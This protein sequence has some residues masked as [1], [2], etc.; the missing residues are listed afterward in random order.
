VTSISAAVWLIAA[1]LLAPAGLVARASAPQAGVAGTVRSADG[2]ALANARVVVRD[3]SHEATAT[4][5]AAGAFTAAGVSLPAVIEVSARGVAPARVVVSAAPVEIR[6]VPVIV[7]EAVTVQGDADPVWRN[8]FTGATVLGRSDI[9]RIPGVAPDETIRAVSGFSLFR[10]SA[11]RAS[12]PTTHGV[13]MRGLS[14]SGSSR[15]LVLLDGV[16]LNDGFG[17]WITW[18]RLPS[19]ALDQISVERGAQGDALGSD[20]LG[21]VVRMT[22]RSGAAAPASV[23]VQSG[24]AG[25]RGADAAAGLRL[26][27]VSLFGAASWFRT[28]GS[29]PLES[30]SRGPIDQKA[31]ADWFSALGRV[32]AG[33]RHR[34]TITAWG[35]RDD[36]GNGTVLQRNRMSGGTFAAAYR[37]AGMI[38]V[39]A[40]V[41][42]SPN[43]FDQTFSQV[44][45]GRA[46]ETLTSTQHTESTTTR[47]LVEVG[48]SVWRTLLVGRASV[49]RA[50]AEFTETRATGTTSQSLRDDGEAVSLQMGLPLA[51][52]GSNLFSGVTITSGVRHEWRKAPTEGEDRDEA[53][54][55]HLN[56]VVRLNSQVH[57]RAS[58]ATSHRWPTLN[59]LVR[60]FQVGAILTL[61]NPALRPERARAA[62]WT[63]IF[64]PSQGQRWLLT[65]GTFW[66][67]VDDAIASVTIATNR[68]ERRNAGDARAK[69][70]E[71]DGEVRPSDRVRLRASATYVR[72]TFT[73]AED[74]ALDGR[75]L[76]Q[77]PR[78]SGSISGDVTL[79]GS[80]VASGL[81]HGVS[82]QFDDDRNQFLLSDGYQLDLRVAGRL[83][84]FGWHVVLENALDSRLEVGRTPLVTLAPGRQ[85]R[86]GLS[87]SRR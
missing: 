85:V 16:P 76:P 72:A 56:G 3:A 27:G 58:Y 29:I 64:Q 28:D 25:T 2:L 80:I 59:E 23:G 61:P 49:T 68:R 6:L 34:M 17:G 52:L 67:V 42:F 66:S 39:A 87:W 74:P 79:P 18:T 11:A 55:A 51:S 65:A 44:G 13:T 37:H 10:R 21:G 71:V 14:A 50:G 47:A 38:D 45:A 73:N 53:T 31:D 22:T 41:S 9:E 75:R 82:S 69:G 33:V 84:E 78:V 8:V 62:D 36:R 63:V 32:D 40:R 26:R 48:R 86:V 57:V 5:D 15:G 30:V 70:V 54:V 60:G 1:S 83:R 4:T 81:W 35:G 24:S 20:A 46:T 19:L 7:S 77:V 43:T 12:N